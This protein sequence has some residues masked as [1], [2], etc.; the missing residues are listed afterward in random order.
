MIHSDIFGIL[1]QDLIFC[2]NSNVDDDFADF[3]Q[4]RTSTQSKRF[5]IICSFSSKHL[6]IIAVL[7]MIF[8]F[9]LR[10]IVDLPFTKLH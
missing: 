8:F 6:K 5:L 1:S 7:T 2:S 3:S 9:A 4:A 10:R